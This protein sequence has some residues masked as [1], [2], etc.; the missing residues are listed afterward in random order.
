MTNI[1]KVKGIL[2]QAKEENRAYV[3]EHEVKEMLAEYDLDVTREQLCKTIDE[4]IEAANTIGYPVVLKIVSPDVVHK[5]DS[6][7]VAVGIADDDALRKAYGKMI[8]TYNAQFSAETLKGISV[9]EMVS[10]EEVIIGAVKDPQFGHMLMVGIGGVFVEVFK[11]VAYRL[12]P[13]DAREAEEMLKELKGYKM[14]TG[15]R[16][17]DPVNIEKL[18]QS[19]VN[20]SRALEALPEIKEMD[21][22]PIFVSDKRAVVAD[23]RIFI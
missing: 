22:N 21:L 10:G 23:G 5:S 2:A 14:L 6:G 13:I 1:E 15:Y 11:D 18:C 17:K 8:S 7:G 16:G 12:A 4:A 9:Q 3:L 20:V 19:L